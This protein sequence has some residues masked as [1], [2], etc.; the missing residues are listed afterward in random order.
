[1][2]PISILNNGQESFQNYDMNITVLYDA[3]MQIDFDD[4]R[5][6]DQTGAQLPYFKL[7]TANGVTCEV[8]VRI[9]TLPPGQTIMYMFYGN[10]SAADQSSFPSIFSWQDR[11]HPDTMVSF[12]AASEGAWDPDVIYG[13]NRFLVTWEERLGPED[14]KYPPPQL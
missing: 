7:N 11:T 13:A 6:A 9:P 14:I 1:M 4:L 12:K 8:L 2:K 3:D 5:F 10:P